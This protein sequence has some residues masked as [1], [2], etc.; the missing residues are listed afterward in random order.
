MSRSLGGLQSRSR[1]RLCVTNYCLQGPRLRGGR[2]SW[3]ACSA[4]RLSRVLPKRFPDREEIATV[5]TEAAELEPGVEGGHEHRLAGRVLARRD[6]GKLMFLDLV[7]RSG[8]IQLLI[9]PDELGGVTVDLG[10]IVGVSGVAT[11][12]RRGEPSLAV[13]SLELLAKI[14][15]PLPDTHHGV[16]DVEQRYRRR[17]LDLLMSEDSRRLTMLRTRIVSE[18]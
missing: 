17:Y 6:M 3:R 5:R 4:V 12:S 2:A 13:R 1:L 18:T 9:R 10:D 16:T 15:V 11:K 14:R 8:R 7:D